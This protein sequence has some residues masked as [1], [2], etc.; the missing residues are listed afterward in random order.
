MTAMTT[1]RVLSVGQCGYDHGNI[2]QAVQ[3]A[4]GAEV[5]P[6]D[7]AAE[8]LQRLRQ[9]EFALVLVNRVLD[10]DGSSGLDLIR[11][12]RHDSALAEVPVMLV[13]NYEDAQQEAAAVGAAPGFGKVAVGRPEMEVR[14]RPFLR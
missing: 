1:K 9:E 4:F 7:S 12:I 6:A 10:A 11:R 8:A 3:Q 13:S 5:I 14:L 2:S